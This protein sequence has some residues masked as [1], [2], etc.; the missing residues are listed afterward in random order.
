MLKGMCFLP[1]MPWDLRGLRVLRG[2]KNR[3]K[4]PRGTQR[5]AEDIN[6]NA[7]RSAMSLFVSASHQAPNGAG[8]NATRSLFFRNVNICLSQREHAPDFK[9]AMLKFRRDFIPTRSGLAWTRPVFGGTRPGFSKERPDFGP[10]PSGLAST[11]SG[12]DSTR[13]YLGSTRSGF[14]WTRWISGSTRSGF[15]PARSG[16]SFQTARPT[17]NGQMDG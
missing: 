14:T 4:T 8:P 9:K 2:G 15:G 5:N 17:D 13:P 10:A 7:A 1:L 3:K 16:R 6:P 11:R 12:S